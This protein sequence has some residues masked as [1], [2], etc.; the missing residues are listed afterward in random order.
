MLYGSVVAATQLQNRG[1]V[2][3]V[4]ATG[5]SSESRNLSG[6]VDFRFLTIHWARPGRIH[7]PKRA[8]R[9]GTPVRS[10]VLWLSASPVSNQTAVLP[11]IDIS[12]VSAVTRLAF[13]VLAALRLCAKHF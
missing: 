8:A 4:V 11:E 3:V 1:A 2:R 5:S 13:S 12:C 7:H 9:L 10:S 6:I